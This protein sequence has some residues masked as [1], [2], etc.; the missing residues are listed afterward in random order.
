MTQIVGNLLYTIPTTLYLMELDTV[1]TVVPS[2]KYFR[3]VFKIIYPV[4]FSRSRFSRF[5][6]YRSSSFYK[7]IQ[8]N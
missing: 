1:V 6:V 5:P 7:V 3:L 8:K 4:V 2:L